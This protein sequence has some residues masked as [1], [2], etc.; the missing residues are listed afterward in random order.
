MAQYRGGLLSVTFASNIVQ[1]IGTL[2]VGNVD[3][4]DMLLITGDTN[5]YTVDT[6]DSNTQLTIVGAYQAS[7]KSGVNYAITRDFTPA[8]G[9]PIPISG[10]IEAIRIFGQAIKMIDADMGTG[11][12]GGGGAIYL[13]DL[14]DVSAINV[15]V[16]NV[17]SKLSDGTF[18]FQ[19]VQA[20]SVGGTNLGAAGTANGAELFAGMSGGNLTFRRLLFQNLT[21]TQTATDI[22]ITGTSSGEVNTGASAGSAGSLSIYKDKLG[23]V[24]RFFGLRAGAGITI[25]PEGDDL[26]FS[27]SGT[28]GGSG[29]ANTTSN[30]GSGNVQLA[31]PKTG[32]NLPFKSVNFPTD[33]FTVTEF[34]NTFT[35][36]F[37]PQPLSVAPDVSVGAAS[38]GQVLRKG[39]DG[40]WSGF[41]LP[42]SGIASV[43]ADTAPALGGDLNT[44]GRK[45][46][47]ITDTFSGFMERPKTKSYTLVLS[48]TKSINL[49]SMVTRCALGTVGYRIDVGGYPASTPQGRPPGAISGTATTTTATATPTSAVLVPAGS[50]LTLTL[51]SV[52][53]SATDFAFSLTYVTA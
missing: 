2:W 7:S 39:S 25:L 36:A 38:V 18:G 32:V 1:G 5:I 24:L 28:G 8:R 22:T 9:Y 10:D 23:T 42:A 53:T 46:L 11:G 31:A 3:P 20:V 21:F 33:R 52:S 17:L 41:T 48:T 12:G 34:S 35:V 13:D 26:V 44:A 16:G 27:S 50:E 49:S 40:L 43:S 4:G 15:P 37:K 45:I 47:G 6:V 29:E 19:S 14:L 51:E 30:I